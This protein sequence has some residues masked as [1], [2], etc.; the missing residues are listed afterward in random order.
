MN[1]SDAEFLGKRY[2]RLIIL[3]FA[4]SRFSGGKKFKYVIVKC[5]CGNTKT[6]LI[7]GMNHDY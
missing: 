6:I 7:K 5:D 1:T 3:D 4:E 2:A